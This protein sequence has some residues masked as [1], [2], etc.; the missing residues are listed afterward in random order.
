MK[1][2][3]FGPLIA[4]MAVDDFDQALAYANDSDYG[5]SAYLFTRDNRKIMRA[6]NELEFGEIYVNARRAR[7]RTA[8]I[9]ASARAAS[10]ARTASMAS[11]ASCTRRRSTTI[12][13]DALT[14]SR[15]G[16]RGS[17]APALLVQRVEQDG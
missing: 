13:R 7:A 14:S 15:T 11:R 1:Q 12:T 10:A 3:T 6:V 2:E 5:L 9:P 4:A 8:S 16:A 17:C